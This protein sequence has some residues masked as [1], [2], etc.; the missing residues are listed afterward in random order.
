MAFVTR[1]TR[2]I[3][4]RTVEKNN[5]SLG[6]CPVPPQVGETKKII[7]HYVF[8]SINHLTYKDFYND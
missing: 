2:V 3:S 7:K 4:G 6:Y 1:A 8:R 5:D